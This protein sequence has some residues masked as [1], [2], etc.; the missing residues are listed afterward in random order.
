MK[1]LGAL[2]IVFLIGTMIGLPVEI[3][4]RRRLRK[5]WDRACAGRDWRR[6]FSDTSKEE[7][8]TYLKIFVEAFAFPYSRKLKFQP[9][10]KIIDV[11]HA[12]YPV[13]GWPDSLE[14]ETFAIMVEKTYNCDLTKEWEPEMTLGQAFA[15]TRKL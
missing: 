15:M 5:Y 14:L 6:E 4:R 3:K 9:S 7:I 11:Y 8:R 13:K 12:C 1:Q 10:D 2:L